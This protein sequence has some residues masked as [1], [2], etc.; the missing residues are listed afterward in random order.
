ML[1]QHDTVASNGLDEDEDEDE[2]AE[3]GANESSRGGAMTRAVARTN[4]PRR[5]GAESSRRATA[6]LAQQTHNNSADTAMHAQP[7]AHSLKQSRLL[8]K[9]DNATQRSAQPDD[10]LAQQASPAEWTE[11]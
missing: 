10:S 3:Q 2:E 9:S 6:A 4:R 8:L 7:G 11:R 5:I 1:S